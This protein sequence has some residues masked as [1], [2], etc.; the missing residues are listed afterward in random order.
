[1]NNEDKKKEIIKITSTFSAEMNSLKERQNKIISDFGKIL[2]E[3]KK[4]EIR[5]KLKSL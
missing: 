1:M 5:N 3:K 4:A 2:E